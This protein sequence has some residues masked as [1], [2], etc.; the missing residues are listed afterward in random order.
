MSF[1]GSGRREAEDEDHTT[2]VANALPWIGSKVSGDQPAIPAIAPDVG[3]MTQMPCFSVDTPESMVRRGA[4]I[5]VDLPSV[6][7]ILA[8]TIPNYRA[9]IDAAHIGAVPVYNVRSGPGGHGHNVYTVADQFRL[10]GNC[11]SVGGSRQDC[12]L[13]YTNFGSTLVSNIFE[14]NVLVEPVRETIAAVGGAG[15]VFRRPV[16]RPLPAGAVHAADAIADPANW[17]MRRNT[18]NPK[19]DQVGTYIFGRPL[20][21]MPSYLKHG[22]VDVEV[23]RAE[24]ATLS[25][26]AGWAAAE[27]AAAAGDFFALPRIQ[28]VFTC[29]SYKYGPPKDWEYSGIKVPGSRVGPVT[30]YAT[31]LESQSRGR[32]KPSKRQQRANDPGM[33]AYLHPEGVAKRHSEFDLTEVQV[34]AL[35]LQ[36][37]GGNAVSPF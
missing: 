25:T 7:A 13:T 10:L 22:T 30:L 3:V 19:V 17:Q 5:V 15:G 6:N 18:S 11:W 4:F 29:G 32:L 16:L 20:L 21:C 31:V 14:K 27:A 12:T 34:I 33:H 9:D 8:E 37:S 24:W 23:C 28:W 2:A 26:A 35:M 1:L 36:M